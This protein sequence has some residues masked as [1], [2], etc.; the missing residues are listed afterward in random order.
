MEQFP[1]TC[2]DKRV[3]MA[4]AIPSNNYTIEL[5]FIDIIIIKIIFS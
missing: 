4:M 2:L 3:A 5:N 1:P